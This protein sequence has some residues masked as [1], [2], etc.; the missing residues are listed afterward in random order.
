MS[1]SVLG[2]FSATQSSKPWGNPLAPLP[3]LSFYQQ[4]VR[5]LGPSTQKH[6]K[7]HTQSLNHTYG[8]SHKWFFVAT[9]NHG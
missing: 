6:T 4:H 2:S 5:F 1:V 3:L 9:G 7:A 8:Y